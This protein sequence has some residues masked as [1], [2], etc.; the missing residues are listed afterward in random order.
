[1]LTE[2]SGVLSFQR[3]SFYHFRTEKNSTRISMDIDTISTNDY[4][5][6]EVNLGIFVI[7]I[8]AGKTRIMFASFLPSWVPTWLAHAGSNRF[9][10]TDTWLHDA[11]IESRSRSVE[12]ED[13]VYASKS[14]YATSLWRKWW[15]E[16]GFS[17]SPPNTYGPSSRSQLPAVPLTRRRQIDPWE[18]HAKHCSSCRSALAT[19]KKMEVAGLLMIIISLA[20]FGTPMNNKSFKNLL[21]QKIGFTISAGIGFWMNRFSKKCATIIEGNPYASGIADRSVSSLS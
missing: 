8:S 5:Q 21:F 17:K 6:Y 9:L 20:M 14:D 11:E 19:M 3:P 15:N 4:D 16:F 7:P 18:N 13:Y 12:K 2:K 1:M 10:N